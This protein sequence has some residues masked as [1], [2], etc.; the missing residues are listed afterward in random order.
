MT[1]S[2]VLAVAV[3]VCLATGREG[4][5]QG[6][7]PGSGWVTVPVDE[8]QALRARARPAATPPPAAAALTRL[9]YALRAEDATVTGTARLTV[10]VAGTGRVRVPM[11]EGLLVRDA[12]I[13][14]QPLAVV[15]G[16]PPAVDLA[17]P[18]RTVVELDIVLTPAAS[19][20]A[21]SITLPSAPAAI[22]RVGLTL[23]G[24]THDLRATGGVVTAQA[25][26]G[27]V[28]TWTVHGQPRTPL[29]LAWTPR[30]DDPRAAAPL[31]MAAHLET[32][33]TVHDAL[34]QTTTRVAIDVQQ[35]LARRV[36]LRV[37]PGLTVTDV[38]GRSVDE[39]RVDESALHVSLVEAAAG[40]I[41]LDV[42]GEAPA[43][44]G[45]TVAVPLVGP[46]SAIERTTGHVTV[47]AG[48]DAEIVA[49]EAPDLE[50]ADRDGP[51]A[52]GTRRF[53]LPPRPA[54][55][56][57]P[58]LTLTVERYAAEAVPVATIDDAHYRVLATSGGRLLV[59]AQYVVRSN[60]RAALHVTMPA[61]ARVWH[62]GVGGRTAGVDTT[63][64]RRL[65]V[66]IETAR[67]GD[68]PA[69]STVSVLYLQ[70]TDTW[71]RGAHP[72]LA[73]PAVDLPIARSAL[74][75]YHPPDVR[76]A[77]HDGPFRPGDDLDAVGAR[78]MLTAAPVVDDTR[79]GVAPDVLA[80]IAG[81]RGHDS[82][83]AAA[84]TAAD[85]ILFPG[86][87]PAVA[88]RADLLPAGVTPLVSLTLR[89][90]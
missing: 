14:G 68:R 62:A 29:V 55:A 26:S 63:G 28:T 19:N 52:A 57:P 38:A 81:A 31:R 24:A 7:P 88:L 66:P 69:V 5:A 21:A 77:V 53:R 8:Y 46:G 59:H 25:T 56:A 23:P 22:A 2:Q 37:P 71:T 70:T 67:A 85:G 34:V 32:T 3:T 41:L 48:A 15:A 79:S 16:P 54:G 75:L 13:D 20:G 27:D 84:N 76:P 36:T 60:Q 86:V 74:L 83:D 1:R 18:G 33:A 65:L 87:G 17:G 35:G 9:D 44:P 6:G 11:P 61:G 80:L 82:Q 4:N 49:V 39:W 47:H 58:R 40:A 90:R 51:A 72:Q 50:R 64:D 42:R 43:P 78:P 10:D 30:R 73:L 12:R 89:A 45:P